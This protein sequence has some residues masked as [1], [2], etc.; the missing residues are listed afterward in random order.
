MRYRRMASGQ[1]LPFV[2]VSAQLE[3]CLTHQNT[4]HTLNTP[5]HTLNTGYTTPT[6]TP[7]PIQSAQVELR[8]GRV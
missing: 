5:Y 6:R 7:Y 8:C 3:L 2:H 1:G 4:V